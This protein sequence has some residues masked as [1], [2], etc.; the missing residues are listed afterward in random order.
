[1]S[2]DSVAG[3]VASLDAAMDWDAATT[4]AAIAASDYDAADLIAFANDAS[5]ATW[6]IAQLRD[7]QEKTIDLPVLAG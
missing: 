6:P 1:M 5:D 2:A 7:D 3:S 4:T